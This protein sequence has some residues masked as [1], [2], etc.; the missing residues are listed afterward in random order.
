MIGLKAGEI[1][2]V[3]VE[4]SN[5]GGLTAEQITRLCCQKLLHVS[6]TAPPEIRVQAEAFRDRIEAVVY[7]YIRDA[8]RAERDRCMQEVSNSGFANLADRRE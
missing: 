4:T 1:P 5:D 6:D 3:F 7:H 2:S 8:M